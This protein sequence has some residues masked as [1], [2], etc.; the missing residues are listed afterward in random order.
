MV[1]TRTRIY[2]HGAENLCLLVS[3]VQDY[4]GANYFAI[5]SLLCHIYKQLDV[6]RC[7]FEYSPYSNHKHPEIKTDMPLSCLQLSID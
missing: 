4:C 3:N 7:N 5:T 2:A 1:H 6:I